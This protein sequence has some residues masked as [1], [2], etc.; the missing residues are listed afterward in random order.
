[1][2]NKELKFKANFDYG[3]Y[4]QDQSDLD[5]VKDICDWNANT[6]NLIKSLVLKILLKRK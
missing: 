6:D 4:I 3:D 2:E 1:M 5:S